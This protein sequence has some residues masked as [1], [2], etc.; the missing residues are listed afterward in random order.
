MARPVLD[1]PAGQ[2][3]F[4]QGG[5][6]EL[7]PEESDTMS[8][9]IVFQ[10]RFAPGLAVT[11]DYFDIQIDDTISTFGANN[12]LDACYDLGDADACARID[13]NPA[14]GSLWIGE[15]N[16]MDLNVNI[17]SLSTKGY[18]INVSYTGLEMGRFGS[19]AFNLTGTYLDELITEPSPGLDIDRRP[20]AL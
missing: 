14:N 3:S 7:T 17:G 8:Y 5:N 15:G 19:L 2:Y 18:D 20:Y 16:V 9:G 1:S 4:L 12:T 6:L 13:R 10:P 11:V